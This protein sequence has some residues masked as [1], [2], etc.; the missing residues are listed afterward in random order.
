MEV[1]R[2]DVIIKKETM[3]KKNNHD[4]NEIYDI[5]KGVSVFMRKNIFIYLCITVES[6]K[7]IIRC[8]SQSYSQN[9]WLVTSCESYS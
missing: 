2:S 7:W 6:W 1:H 3:I 5:D 8:C 9:F 4:I